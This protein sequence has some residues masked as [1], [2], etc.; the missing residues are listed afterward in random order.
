MRWDEKKL[1][2]RRGTPGYNKYENRI[3]HLSDYVRHTAYRCPKTKEGLL[4]PLRIFV[5]SARLRRSHRQDTLVPVSMSI[6][7]LILFFF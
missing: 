4:V 5:F 2:R 6:F 7:L 1:S 3:C